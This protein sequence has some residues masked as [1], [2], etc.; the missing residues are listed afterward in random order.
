M[1]VES[2][3]PSLLFFASSFLLWMVGWWR[4]D[5]FLY[6]HPTP[7]W[8]DDPS[9]RLKEKGRAERNLRDLSCRLRCSLRLNA[10]LQ[11]WHLYFSE[12]SACLTRISDRHSLP[13]SRARPSCGRR[14]TS[15]T[16]S[17]W[18]RR[19]VWNRSGVWPMMGDA[20]QWTEDAS[21]QSSLMGVV[22]QLYSSFIP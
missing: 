17:Q 10:R 13:S 16:P 7:P 20:A 4:G 3:F 14:A 8:E 22:E 19:M 18:M 2:C 1:N 11:N 6:S 12:V 15:W 9:I 21:R 5:R